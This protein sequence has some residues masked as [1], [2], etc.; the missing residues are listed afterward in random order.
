MAVTAGIHKYTVAESNNLLLGQN[1]FKELTTD[2]NTGDGYFVA[3]QIIGPATA[4]EDDPA[5]VTIAT[6]A[7]LGDPMT[8]T[9]LRI[10]TIVYGAFKRIT[11]TSIGTNVKVLCY[12]G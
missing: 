10:G 7:H 8:A 6:T 9:A 11:T 12:Y 3:F 2:T 5:V 1:G 4:Y